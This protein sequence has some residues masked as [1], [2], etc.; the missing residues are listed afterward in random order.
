MNADLM[1]N[2]PATAFVSRATMAGA[3]QL[4]TAIVARFRSE[5]PEYAALDADLLEGDVRRVTLDNLRMLLG[6]LDASQP[7]SAHELA[8]VRNGA[9]RRGHQGVPLE[10]MLRAYRLWAQVIWTDVAGHVDVTDAAEAQAALHIAAR[11]LEHLDCVASAVTQAHGEEQAAV[12]NV[13]DVIP[14]DLLDQLL[15]SR[16]ESEAAHAELAR[17]GVAVDDRHVVVVIRPLRPGQDI[18]PIVA[19]PLT[20]ARISRIVDLVRRHLATDA[21]PAFLGVRDDEIVVLDPLEDRSSFHGLRERCAM[22][23]SEQ[24]AV[25]V[26]EWHDGPGAIPRSYVEARQAAEVAL[27]AGAGG[28]AIAFGEVLIDQLLPADAAAGKVIASTVDAVEEY[29]AAH[30]TDLMATLGAYFEAGFI[31]AR[32]ASILYVQPNTVVY[33]LKRIH[34]LTGRDPFDPNGLMLLVLAWKLRRSAR[35]ETD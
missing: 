22:L 12:I 30:H 20:A 13:S 10:A 16:G 6:N 28:Q 14:R 7:L 9:L 3:E 8:K 18:V 32:A 25:D 34:Q 4:A 27:I 1:P 31:L 15:T 26:G 19:E 24:L 33:R 5:I 35:R 29:D 11:L 2:G 23:A 17:R 21:G